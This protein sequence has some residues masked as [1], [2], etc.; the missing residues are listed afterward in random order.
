MDDSEPDIVAHMIKFIY[1]QDYDD[2]KNR[3]STTSEAN[4]ALLTNVKVY[5]LGDKYDIQPMKVLAAKKYEALVPEQWNTPSFADSLKL[6]YDQTLDSDR[7]M[8]DMAIKIAGDHA[9]KQADRTE[10]LDLCQARGDIAYDVLK[11]TMDAMYTGTPGSVVKRCP[12]ISCGSNG[13]M[14]YVKAN[15]NPHAVAGVYFR[16]G[17]SAND[18]KFFCSYC[19]HNFK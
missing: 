4:G 5:I 10:F 12:N 15:I 16:M 11:F 18:A 3:P 7:M 2:G 8:K 6:L 17:S 1:T 9:T 13:N 19:S 14:N